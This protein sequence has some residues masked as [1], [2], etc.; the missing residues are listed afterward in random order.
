MRL[1]GNAHPFSTILV[2]D[3]AIIGDNSRQRRQIWKAADD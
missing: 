1:I 3:I 2:R